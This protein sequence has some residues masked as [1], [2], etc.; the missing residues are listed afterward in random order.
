M[1][2]MWKLTLPLFNGRRAVIAAALLAV[3]P[4]FALQATLSIPEGPLLAAIVIAQ[5][6]LLRLYCNRD[7]D[8]A[9]GWWLALLFWG[10]QGGA[11]LVNALAVPILSLSTI[12]ALYVMDRR[13]DWLARLR[14]L[15]GVPLMLAIA[16]P[17]IIIR[18]HFDGVPFS[19]LTWGEFIRALGGA[20]D[21]KWKAAPL[22]FTLAFV[23]GFLPGA[24]LLVPA[25]T[26][27]WRERGAAL[28]RFLFAWIVGYWLYLELIASKPALYT[29]QAMFPAA[30]AAVALALDRG[31]PGAASPYGTLAIPPRMLRLPWWLVLAGTIALFA[32][33]TNFAAVPLSFAV[34]AGAALVT[35]LF[36]LAAA[37]AKQGLA[38]AWITSAVAGF[39]LLIAYTFGVLMPHSQIGWPAPLIADAIAPLRRCVTGPVGVVGFREPSTNFVLGRGTNT[40]VETIA[41]WMAGG[42]DAIAVVEDRW[43]TDLAKALA[44]KGGK[45]PARLGCI[46]A[47]NVMRGCPVD[48]SIY[49][50]G[51]DMLDPGCKIAER[52]TCSIPLPLEPADTDPR[53]RCR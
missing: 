46:E 53:S 36:T 12:V 39:A 10:A 3:S 43:Q 19:G 51:G 35:A 13:V 2:V 32:V 27:L 26:N 41:G 47:F 29:V 31:L 24:L 50:T 16:A 38:A 52:Y 17:W 4:V 42:E 15:T 25:L 22:T 45:A 6:A 30:A 18:A 48:F 5:L 37:A 49:V 20:Q 40:N 1:L 34:I 44:A 28:Q 8:A 23:L 9:N 14:P 7:F 33:L 11:I 21:M